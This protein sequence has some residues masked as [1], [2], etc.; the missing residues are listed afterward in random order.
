LTAVKGRAASEEALLRQAVERACVIGGFTRARLFLRDEEGE[1]FRCRA[2]HGYGRP[3]VP[4]EQAVPADDPIAEELARHRRPF[5]SNHA[6][7]DA[8]LRRS[9]LGHSSTGT[10]LGIQV[11]ADGAG[12]VGLLVLEDDAEITLDRR[13][14]D[15]LAAYADLVGSMASFLDAQHR[16]RERYEDLSRRHRVLSIH[17]S[18]ERRLSRLAGGE[19]GLSKIVKTA[20]ELAGKVVALF[21]SHQRLVTSAG[22]EN[23]ALIRVQ[24]PAQILAAVSR[25]PGA[26]RPEPTVV[27]AQP[28]KGVTRR[29]IVTPVCGAGERFGWLVMVEYPSR[30]LP[31]D[32]FIVSRTAEYLGREFVIQRR[33]AGV[34][35]NAR[36][37]LARQL[38]RGT[39]NADDLRSCGEYLGVDIDA[40]RVLAYVLGSPAQ[41][42]ASLYDERLATEIGRI[43]GLEV[44][45]TRGSE[46]VI[47]LVEAPPDI[48]PIVMVDRVKSAIREAVA[49][50]SHHDVAVG[51][52]AVCEPSRLPRAYREARE[53]AHCIDRFVRGP[54]ARILAVDDLGPARLFV[55]NGDA[56]SVRSYV[57][58]VLGPLCTDDPGAANLLRTLQTYFDSGLSVRVA[59]AKLGVHENTI[60]FR[61]ARVRE[62]TGLDVAGKASDQLSVQTALLVLRLK[63]HPALPS[64]DYDLERNGKKTA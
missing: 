52:S 61:L 59:A 54:S 14:L 7:G 51:V 22:P 24:P 57:D 62:A 5:L 21:D 56:A 1:Q 6:P 12:V 36:A 26:E 58:D 31:L 39:S 33:V 25:P 23:R 9:V 38:V 50:L 28:L 49:K 40:R 46:G 32:T 11:H 4:G 41:R 15:Q 37:S 43:L 42:E 48:S 10:L 53:V 29:H 63:G 16:L 60:R 47:L 45:A 27:P 3:A 44:L 17:H 13:L 18:V 30:L 8:R 2:A 55:A 34:A 20:A 19:G 64:F 35:W